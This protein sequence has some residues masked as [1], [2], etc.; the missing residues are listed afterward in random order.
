M[1]YFILFFTF[2]FFSN[3]LFAQVD[4]EPIPETDVKL[5]HTKSGNL[6]FGRITDIQTNKGIEAASIQLYQKVIEP[7]S[8][9]PQDSLIGAMLS[10]PNG[11]FSFEK[12]SLNGSF[13]VKVSAIGYAPYSKVFKFSAVENKDSVANVQKDLGNIIMNRE[14]EKLAAVT[15]VAERPA[16][17]LGIDKRIFDVDKSI[18]SKGGTA[19]D[20]MKNIPSVSVDVD[21]NIEMRNS[22]PT[23]FIDGRP[24]ILTLDQIASDDI[25]RIEI[26][27]NPSAKYDASSTGGIINIILKKNK[28]NGLNGIA[29]LTAGTPKRYSG[30]ANLNLRQGKFNFFVNGQYSYSDEDSKANSS[31]ENKNNGVITD[32]FNQNT[33]NERERKFSSIRF[34]ADYFLDNRNTITLSQGFVS[35]R[36]ETDQYQEQQYADSNKVLVKNGKRIADQ[37]FQFT[38]NNTQLLYTHKFPKDGETLDVTVNANYGNVKNNATILNTFYNPDGTQIGDLSQVRNDGAND[39][40]QLTAKVDYVNPLGENRKLEAGLRSFTNNY[41]SYFNSFSVNGNTETKL[42]LSNNYKYTENIQ[43]A[44]VTYTGMAK[45]IGYQVGL[46]GEYSKLAGT[47]IDSSKKFGY[48]YPS[49]LKNIWDVLFPSL[50]LSRKIGESDEIQLNYARK[51]RRPDFWQLNPFFDINDPLNIQVGNPRL[52]PEFTNSLEFNYSKNFKNNSN[53]LGTIYYRN[54]LGDITRYSDTISA[55]QYQHLQNAGVDPNAIVNTFINANNMNQAGV[56]LTLQ[57]KLAK[58]FTISPSVNLG[59]RR[60]NAGADSM[61]LSNEGFNWSGKFNVDY[62]INT[63]NEL[64]VFNKLAFQFRAAYHSPRVIPQGKRLE[65]FEADFAMRKD[66]FKGNK[67]TIT[68]SVNDIFNSQGYGVI[69]DTKTFYQEAYSRWSVRNFRLTFSYKFGDADFSLFKKNNSNKDDDNG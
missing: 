69:Y 3:F 44:Y 27:T 47:L 1:R 7:I 18:T 64:S 2:T 11:D 41:E 8:E 56:E 51:I 37:G 21:G 19:I 12:I 50:Y 29:S 45:N 61:N 9:Q 23:I 28:R 59:Y 6:I 62:K 34:G 16:M 58:D 46:R 66:L 49:S 14:H 20:V 38:K 10:K 53:F 63:K 17:S 31:R 39:N 5:V 4:R 60:V 26:I 25:D 52:K 35:G 55:D 33:N 65:R 22:S 68:F 40:N 42:P 43:A 57:Q 13:E 32:Y 67:G 24:T 48:E 15:I 30:N 54:T 36:F